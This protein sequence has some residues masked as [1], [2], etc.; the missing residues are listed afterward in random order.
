MKPVAQRLLA[1]AGYSMWFCV[2]FTLLTWLTFPWSRVRDHAI[3]A[4]SDAGLSLQLDSLR[5]SSSSIKARGMAVSSS[6]NG[7]KPWLSL[8]SLKVGSS[9]SGVLSSVLELR[10][11]MAGSPPS[12]SA[13]ATQR[14]LS[15]LSEV[16]IDAD[17]YGGEFNLVAE[18]DGAVSRINS[19][20]DKVN[21]D[22]Y[23]IALRT[24]SAN[25]KGK[26]KGGSDLT[27]HCEDAKKSSGSIDFIANGLILEGLTVAGCGLPET[28][29]DR[30]EAHIK[31]SRGRA[32]FRDTAFD[33]DVVQ[34]AIEG[35]INLNT[36]L[37]RSRLALR[38]RFKVRDDLDG[39]LK[40]QFGSNPRHKDARGWYHY[41]V[42]GTLQRPRLRE[43]P[44]AARRGR[45]QSVSKPPA[46]T[47]PTPAITPQSD[48]SETETEGEDLQDARRRELDEE[49]ERLREERAR[50]R[51]DRKRKRE[52]LIS[53]R[54]ER[55]AELDSQE[56][57]R[58][59]PEDIV[60][61]ADE[62]QRS[63]FQEADSG[64][65]TEEEEP[66]AEEQQVDIET[67]SEAEGEGEE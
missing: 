2:V 14:I 56:D 34:V 54:N 9:S 45:K 4:A 8:E 52:E 39:L 22:Q 13:E 48:G 29:F 6:D 40:V 24:L 63:N 38:M 67:E 1:L 17:L 10:S 46:T 15:A 18:S 30:S 32:E 27:W 65:E 16:Q 5:L 25:P 31:V 47:K 11:M 36:E 26:L 42:N 53:K 41:Q 51:E 58:G 33:S 20:F 44:A 60:L 50:R 61:D 21:L 49:R 7:A 35:Y 64:S 19:V 12:N 62:L 59:S 3:V 43:S 66:G 37:P 55:Q 57:T 28:A 23:Q